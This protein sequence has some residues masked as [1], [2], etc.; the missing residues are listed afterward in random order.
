MT[1]KAQETGKAKSKLALKCAHYNAVYTTQPVVNPVVQ[2]FD[3]RLYRVY[4]HLP[5]CQTG[6]I[7][8]PLIIAPD[9]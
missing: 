4:K 3:N 7:T 2:R 6:L 8:A 5:G 9:Q 1:Q